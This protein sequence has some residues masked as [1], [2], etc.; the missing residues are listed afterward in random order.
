MIRKIFRPPSAGE[1]DNMKSGSSVVRKT[2]YAGLLFLVFLVIYTLYDLS[3]A[4]RMAA[5]VCINA[6]QGMSLEDFLAKYSGND[7]KIIKGA[8]HIIIVPKKAWA[9][10][11]AQFLMTNRKLQDQKQ[12]LMIRE[13]T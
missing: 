2:A 8:G 7:Y 5:D 1:A 12:G 11:P 13:R 3:Q 6:Q 10:I 9:A 4:K